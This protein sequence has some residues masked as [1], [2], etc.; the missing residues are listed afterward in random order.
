VAEARDLA[1][2]K[3]SKLKPFQ[4]AVQ[5]ERL[6]TLFSMAIEQNNIKAATQ[7]CA[8]IAKL[9]GLYAPTKIKMPPVGDVGKNRDQEE[10]R[11][12]IVKLIIPDNGR[13]RPD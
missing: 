3:D 1:C 4:R 13:D 11:Q 8:E 10:I 12:T 7:V 2:Q 6:E 5:A 9:H